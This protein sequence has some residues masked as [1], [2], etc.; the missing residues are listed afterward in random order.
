VIEHTD[1]SVAGGIVWEGVSELVRGRE[2]ENCKKRWELLE[3]QVGGELDTLE[4][5]A[6]QGDIYERKIQ[7]AGESVAP[8]SPLEVRFR[9]HTLHA[10]TVRCTL[11][12][13]WT[14][15]C[16]DSTTTVV[17]FLFEIF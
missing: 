13:F 17:C 5:G 9:S 6:D 14:D 3:A 16:A 1:E 15:F 12:S 11:L 7:L 2:V 4:E 10:S 8:W